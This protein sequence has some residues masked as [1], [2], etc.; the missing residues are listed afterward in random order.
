M[1]TPREHAEHIC[2]VLGAGNDPCQIDA[3]ETYI[4]VYILSEVNPPRK[5]NAKGPVRHFPGPTF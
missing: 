1:T 4:R 2:E 5:E 3:L